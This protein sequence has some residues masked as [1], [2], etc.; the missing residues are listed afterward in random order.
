VTTLDISIL[1][2]AYAKEVLNGVFVVPI[3]KE[4]YGNVL[5]VIIFLIS[6]LNFYEIIKGIIFVQHWG[7]RML[8]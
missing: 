7:T 6:S 1:C 8:P 4:K 5:K 3:S 2:I